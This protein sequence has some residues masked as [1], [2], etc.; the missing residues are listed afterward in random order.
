MTEGRPPREQHPEGA[1]LDAAITEN[2]KGL[3]QGG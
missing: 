2:P 1:K 3:G